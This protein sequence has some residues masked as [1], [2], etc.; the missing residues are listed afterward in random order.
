MNIGNTIPDFTLPDQHGNPFSI[1]QALG[2]QHLVL[3]F[4]PKDNTPG[5]TKE[6]CTFRDWLKEFESLDAKV[7]GISADSVASH[8]AFAKK[9]QLNFTLLSDSD[10][11][12]RK[13][14][15]VPSDIFGLLDGRVTYVVD[16][17]G[18]I[19]HIF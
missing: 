10:K 13:L 2:K 12:V 1:A 15:K 19:R 9:Y 14:L 3:Y 17:E 7:I 4:Y 5:C 16:K 8:Q 18:V 11:K 6:A